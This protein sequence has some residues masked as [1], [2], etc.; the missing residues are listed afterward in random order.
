MSPAGEKAIRANRGLWRMRKLRSVVAVLVVLSA[1]LWRIAPLA[2]VAAAPA[3]DAIAVAEAIERLPVVG[4]VLLTGAHP[5]D[6]NNALLAYLARGL[7]LRT[8]Y[9]SA[10]RGDGG[11]N[12]LGTEQYE[13]LGIL[14]TEELL[15]ARNRDGAVQYFAQAYDFGFS[16]R[17]DE[18]LEKW[19]RDAVLSDY[20]RTIRRIRPDVIISRFTGTPADGHGHHQASGILTKEAYRVAADASRFPEQEAEGLK[21]WLA[22]RLVINRGGGAGRGA[23]AEGFTVQL[24]GFTPLYGEQLG[25]LGMEARSNHRSQGMGGA[26][27]VA[28]YSTSFVQ[29]DH[30]GAVAPKDLFDGIDL[31]LGRF[32]K[33]AGGN[34]LVGAT[35][36]DLDKLIQQVKSSLSPYEP[37][38]A[39]PSLIQGLAL[40]RK[41]RQQFALPNIS[42]EAKDQA[43]FLL[44]EKEEDFERAINLAGGVVFTA[45][46]DAGEIVPG[47]TFHVTVSGA[48][49]SRAA[50]QPGV[51]QLHAPRGWAIK[52]T[53]QPAGNSNGRIEAAF[54][55]TVP[56]DAPVSQPYWLILPRRKEVF[57]VAPSPWMGDAVD[58]ALLTVRVPLTLTD[59]QTQTSAEGR[60]DVVYGYTDRIYGEREQP[61]AVV[62]ALGVWL[63]P[64]VSVFPAGT[65]VTRQVRVRV[66]SNLSTPQT[67][68]V[69][70]QLP[71]GWMSQPAE[72]PAKFSKLGE[73]L[74]FR[75]EVSAPATPLAG[76]SET[77]PVTAL[78]ESAGKKFTS[79]YTV[80][81]YPHV[82]TRYWFQPAVGKLLRLNAKLAAGLK[83]GYIMGSGDDVATGLQQLGLNVTQLGPDDVAYGNLKQ[84][85]VIVTGIRAFEVRNDLATSFP[86]LDEYVKDGG[87]LIVQYSRPGGLAMPWAPYPLSMGD[88]P[89]VS[90]EE[91]P[92]ELLVPGHPLFNVPNK[93]TSDDFKGW[94]Q[95][96]GTY[97]METWDPKFTPLLSSNDPGEPPQKGGMLVANYGK[98]M[99]AYTGYVWFRQL[100]AGNAG[101]YRIV[102]NL[103][104]MAA[105]SKPAAGK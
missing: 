22:D 66:R 35:V 88:G 61:L 38:K 7:H 14:R 43:V 29:V 50:M 91:S 19:D 10:T 23:P 3:T 83:V 58:P 39:L 24:G 92:V 57:N 79:G 28:S 30:A 73:E 52:Q 95:E 42:A 34:A 59:G 85:N 12:L 46:A 5:D 89:R 72:S 65:R 67:A 47:G 87:Y 21:P 16:K 36:S 81:S 64:G 55:V 8:A 33:L 98:G 17:A 45:Y 6:E 80:I 76:V 13:A 37:E 26:R 31:S 49:R 78:A 96:R 84:Y 4:T 27:R 51:P 18:T 2:P 69:T 101:A 15:A 11:Q 53:N 44:G 56:T 40:V 103:L 60:R 32:N 77:S 25:D 41:L 70:L 90:V 54:E 100:P 97:F 1:V 48:V 9:L 99:Y 94:V 102:A 104:S 74:S 93:I 68:T 82:S 63:E 20:V 75:F 105:S 71:V 62:P 86:R